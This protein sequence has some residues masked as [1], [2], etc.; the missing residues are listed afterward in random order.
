LVTPFFTGLL[1]IRL[2]IYLSG[3]LW[4]TTGRKFGKKAIK[5]LLSALSGHEPTK[6]KKVHEAQ[7]DRIVPTLGFESRLFINP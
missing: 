6:N 5:R 7:Q 3:V 2:I 1:E 4:G